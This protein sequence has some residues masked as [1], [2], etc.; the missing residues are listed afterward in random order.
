[1]HLITFEGSR[2]MFVK[3]FTV[4]ETVFHEAFIWKMCPVAV[5]VGSLKCLTEKS[6]CWF[7]VG[8]V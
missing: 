5:Y 6:K 3:A 1:M 2:K 7:K 8:C 4:L